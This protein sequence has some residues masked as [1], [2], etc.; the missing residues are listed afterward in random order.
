[1]SFRLHAITQTAPGAAPTRWAWL[2]HGILGSG[3]NLRNVAR[4]LVAADPSWGFV[5]PDLRN[6]GDSAGAPPPQTVAA[7]A[8]DLFAL[9]DA[10]GIHPTTAI[11]HSFGGKVAL[12]WGAAA[13]ARGDV[14]ERVWAL[15]VPPGLPDL[16]LA[17]QSEVVRVVSAL[18]TIPMP[19]PRR[20][21][22]VERLTTLGFGPMLAQWMTTNLRAAREEEA[23]GFFW[24]FDLDGIE[25]MLQDYARTD[26][27][28]W[29]ASPRRRARVDVVRAERSERWVDA[30]LERFAHG[31]PGV[32]LHVLPDSGHW[33]HVDNPD[34][35]HGLFMGQGLGAKF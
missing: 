30:E 29:L 9:A 10:L 11:G 21:A 23:P 35:L 4:R 2:L 7:C 16:P 33:V 31:Y 32:H 12:V 17:L 24:R 26:A 34:G 14:V 18:R 3:Q 15:D 13:E 19:L 28:P 1:M 27:W 6:H 22:I 20:D 25:A 5:L 8:E